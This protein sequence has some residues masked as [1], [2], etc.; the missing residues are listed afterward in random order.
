MPIRPELRP[1][2]QTPE[3]LEAR[4]R[5]Y[6]RADGHC[7]RCGSMNGQSYLAL[8]SKG[9]LRIDE[10]GN[11]KLSYVQLGCAHL[12]H[13]PRNNSDA[14]LAVLCRA[15]HLRHDTPLHVMHARETRKLHKDSQRPLLAAME[16]AA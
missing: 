3:W 13:D 9:D 11:P 7:E 1:Y 5:A 4:E 14:N 12:D 10:L 2:Y 6:Q 8:D 15:C 16:G